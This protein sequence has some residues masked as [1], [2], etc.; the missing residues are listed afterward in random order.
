MRVRRHLVTDSNAINVAF[1]GERVVSLSSND[2]ES[3]V[4]NLLA[5]S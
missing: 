4:R 1:D 2:N 3:G 5:S